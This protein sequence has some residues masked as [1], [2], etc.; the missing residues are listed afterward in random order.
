MKEGLKG[1]GFES[2]EAVKQK[3][4]ETINTLTEND[5]KH[6]VEQLKIRM[7]K[8]GARGGK[9]IEG[10]SCKE[11]KKKEL[12]LKFRFP[13]HAYVNVYSFCLN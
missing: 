4:T 6:C 3:A 11:K 1:T 7:K 2:V 12:H 9:C 13:S 8:Y 10:K 5:L